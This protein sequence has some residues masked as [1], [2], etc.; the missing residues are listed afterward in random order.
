MHSFLTVLARHEKS[1]DRLARQKGIHFG[2]RSIRSLLAGMLACL[3]LHLD[4]HRVD[5]LKEIL[6][7][8]HPLVQ[9]RRVALPRAGCSICLVKKQK[10]KEQLVD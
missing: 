4:V 6:N 2:H 1:R 9:K 3:T 5:D 10:E 8:S 7:A